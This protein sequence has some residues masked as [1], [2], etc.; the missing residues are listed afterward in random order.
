M[1]PTASPPILI[2]GATGRSGSAVLEEL[3]PRWFP[4]EVDRLDSQRADRAEAGPDAQ[5]VARLK[6]GHR[7]LGLLP[8]HDR[9]TAQVVVRGDVSGRKRR[10]VTTARSVELSGSQ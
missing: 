6:L 1:S 5:R 8:L 7:Q 4:G 10:T 9:A 3:E 2:V